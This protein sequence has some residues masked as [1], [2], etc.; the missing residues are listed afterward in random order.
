MVIGDS[1]GADRGWVYQLQQLRG[2]GPLVNT[3]VSG[4]TI[5]FDGE[6][7]LRLNTL[8]NLTPYLR[9]GYAEMGQIDEVLIALGTNDCKTEFGDRHDQIAQNLD[10]LIRRT[11][12]FFA[13]RG[14]ETPRIV[15]LTPPPA[16]ADEEVIEIFQG[17]QACTAQLSEEIKELAAREGFCVVD[18]QREPGAA[19]LEYSDDGIHFNATG[20]ELIARS[21]IKSCY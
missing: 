6:G 18:L 14:Q 15:L 21:V 9:K 20:Y 3:A 12:T 5:G 16:G 17:V 1:N 10:T 19:V 4:N 13:D 8:E 2:G 7:K 11:R